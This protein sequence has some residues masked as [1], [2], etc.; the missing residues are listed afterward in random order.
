[1]SARF[2]D[3]AGSAL[4][5]IES[6]GMDSLPTW[7]PRR[8]RALTVGGQ[9]SSGVSVCEQTSGTATRPRVVG[10]GWVFSDDAVSVARDNL[11]RLC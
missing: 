1:M 3:V 5:A 9:A 8:R 11:D 2:A 7:R 10:D 4:S 6:C